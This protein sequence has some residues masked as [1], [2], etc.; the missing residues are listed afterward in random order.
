MTK[1]VKE[2]YLVAKE[3]CVKRAKETC[4]KRAKQTCVKR[5]KETYM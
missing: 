5:A 4:V 2:T 3:A 1:R